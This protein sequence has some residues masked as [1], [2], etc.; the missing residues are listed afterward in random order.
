MSASRLK[1][2]SSEG[3]PASS[4]IDLSRWAP[5][6]TAYE[7][8]LRSES[9]P[10]VRQWLRKL[11]GRDP[12]AVEG[13]IAEAAAW[14]FLASHCESCRLHE[15]PGVGGVD[16]EF[17]MRG[18]S[19]LVEVTNISTDA[20]TAASGMPDTE[21]FKG[22]YGL[23]TRQLRDKVRTKLSQAAKN[24]G[25]PTLI[26]VT[27]L[28]WNAGHI[29]LSHT[30]I[31]F[32]M[33][34]PPKITG[35]LNR[36]TG[37]TEGELYQSTDL[38]QSVFLTPSPILGPDGHPV[39]QARFQPISGFLVGG[40]GARPEDVRV[41][42]GLNPEAERPFDPTLLPDTPFCSFREWPV[43]DRIA[44]K[45]TI[46]DDEQDEKQRGAAERRL[47]QAGHGPILDEIRDEAARGRSG[48]Q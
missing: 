32:A 34:S 13:A 40:F 12:T 4:P 17:T 14:D 28:H 2:Q 31:E 42:G 29:C 26:F 22:C 45:W 43:R 33:G 47:R 24:P 30:A 6:L 10:T 41:L 36:E 25:R 1:Q 9:E 15:I 11:S 35:R 21:M 20:A 44:F 27:T 48:D 38:S 39:A 3:A 23:L 5:S 37:A 46:T 19:F 8:W 16:F 7:K 18:Q